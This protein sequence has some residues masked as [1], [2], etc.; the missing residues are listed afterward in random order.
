MEA[1]QRL[2]VPSYSVVANYVRLDI[3]RL[4]MGTFT[5]ETLP[6]LWREEAL[7]MAASLVDD[8]A[9][10]LKPAPPYEGKFDVRLWTRLADMMEVMYANKGIG[11]AA[12]QV[13][14]HTRIFVIDLKPKGTRSPMV[15]INPTL[16]F[17]RKSGGIEWAR[18]GCLS[19][20]GR[21]FTV[22]RLRR[23]N[24]TALDTW[25]VPWRGSAMGLL[26]RAIQHEYNHL[27]GKLIGELINA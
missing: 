27:D 10:L 11:I 1:R 26:A 8:P 25:G 20:P 19:L 12:P 3:G 14:W 5:M 9:I 6:T 17:S 18:E 24:F 13:G 23:L 7:L 21:E 22:G 4:F 2:L 16:S 15:F